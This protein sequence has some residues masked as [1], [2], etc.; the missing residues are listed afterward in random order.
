V[1]V[2]VPV[3]VCGPAK[4]SER[5]VEAEGPEGKSDDGFSQ[6][7][8]HRD[9]SGRAMSKRVNERTRKRA[10]ERASW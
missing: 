3:R 10:N 4:R 6:A 5:V 1:P 2:R 7:R 9:P 8:A